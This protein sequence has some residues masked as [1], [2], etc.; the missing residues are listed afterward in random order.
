MARLL[1]CLVLGASLAISAAAQ[2]TVF[3][4]GSDTVPVFVTVTDKDGRLMTSLTREQFE[5]RDNGKPQPITVF[6]NTPQ[7]IHLIVMIDMSGSMAGNL[8]LLRTASHQLFARLREG[9]VVRVGTF[10]RTVEIS[11]AFEPDDPELRQALPDRSDPNA[12]TPLWRAVDDA[13]S[14][15]AEVQGRRVVLVLSDGKDSGPT[16]FNERF[17]SQLDI[18]DRAAREDVMIYGIGLRSRSMGGQV[19]MPMPGGGSLRDA[20]LDDMPDPGLA[21]TAEES[22]GGYVELRPRDDL[23]A[24]FARIAD[25]LHSQYLLGFAPPSTDGKSHKIEVRLAEKGLKARARRS[26][27]APQRPGA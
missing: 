13:I 5:V 18:V 6:D 7:P 11:P 1:L 9:D 25:E 4:A 15:F 26:Y 24:L 19:R 16:R 10:G 20:L 2:Q 14:A 27:Q 21:R 23:G 22:G 17:V 3:R 8:P 12:P